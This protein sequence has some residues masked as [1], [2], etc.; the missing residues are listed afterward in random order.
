MTREEAI[1]ILNKYDLSF[2]D[3]DGNP[4]PPQDVAEACD[5]AIEA[6]QQEPKRGKW[7]DDD[8]YH[9]KYHR[10]S[11]CGIGEFNWGSDNYCRNCGARMDGD[12][13]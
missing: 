8:P 7:I 5:M 3:I 13:E 4:I 1:E 9:H 2:C 10:C 6:L 12:E 11:C